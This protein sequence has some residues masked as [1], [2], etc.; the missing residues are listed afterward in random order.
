MK[1]SENRRN[2]NPLDYDEKISLLLSDQ[3]SFESVDQIIK[4]KR[5]SI[6]YLIINHK[7]C[8]ENTLLRNIS[9]FSSKNLRKFGS[10]I[11]P[12]EKKSLK[13]LRVSFLSNSF[14]T[15]KVL[16][17]LAKT[18]DYEY[19][20]LLK[21]PNADQ[22]L[23]CEFI[24]SIIEN[25]PNGYN[26]DEALNLAISMLKDVDDPFERDKFLKYLRDG[27]I[28]YV[29]R[30]HLDV[31]GYSNLSTPIK[32][33]LIK[34][35]DPSYQK[36]LVNL[37]KLEARYMEY[38]SN[39]EFSF[40]RQSLAKRHDLPIDIIQ[41]LSTDLDEYVRCA[42]AKNVNINLSFLIK[43]I[44][45]PNIEVKRSLLSRKD[46]PEDERA[47]LREKINIQK[48][49]KTK[50]QENKDIIQSQETTKV[51]FDISSIK[52]PKFLSVR[53]INSKHTKILKEALKGF[54]Y[55]EKAHIMLIILDEWDQIEPG[56]VKRFLSDPPE[57]FSKLIAG[58][59][60]LRLKRMRFKKYSN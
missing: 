7:Y 50:K 22:A 24:W 14:C 18:E 36:I 28:E 33:F 37:E 54:T 58:D 23:L 16:R 30:T 15:T 39:S 6:V 49:K 29:F 40:I 2:V 57:G 56:Y 13:E 19:Y 11:L 3:L 35:H 5:P 52:Y 27:C 4:D 38:I 1:I 21:H 32:E 25:S 42:L 9:V 51:P 17:H 26:N 47:G 10:I 60:V 20:D 59:P 31:R 48:N 34:S 46:L 55:Q 45:D 8:T 12:G 41:K 53:E 44:N 43:Y